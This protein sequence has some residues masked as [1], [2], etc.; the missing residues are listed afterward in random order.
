MSK[1]ITITDYTNDELD[2]LGD[3]IHEKLIDMGYN[4][5]GGFKFNI[6]VSDTAY[7]TLN[8]DEVQS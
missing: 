5:T 4:P 3:M 8:T 1:D 7:S 6:I 2:Y